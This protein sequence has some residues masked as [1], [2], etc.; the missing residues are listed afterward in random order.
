MP[1]Y[2]R[3][4]SEQRRSSAHHVTTSGLTQSRRGSVNMNKGET[5]GLPVNSLQSRR[6]SCP[7][8][9]FDHGTPKRSVSSGSYSRQPSNSSNS[10]KYTQG[11]HFD[12]NTINKNILKFVLILAI[13]FVI[14]VVTSLYRLL[15]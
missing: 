10:A 8:L 3:R 5:L 11:H 12:K 6:G 2:I 13:M 14:V 1:V 7:G 9:K 4:S 15:T